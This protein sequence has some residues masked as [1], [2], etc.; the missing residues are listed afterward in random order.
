MADR[1]NEFGLILS[2]FYALGMWMERIK[3]INE[4]VLLSGK[5]DYSRSRQFAP[6]PI[7]TTM[8][9]ASL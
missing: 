2:G 9:T 8:G 7:S 6:E 3:K 4:V 1:E 5:E